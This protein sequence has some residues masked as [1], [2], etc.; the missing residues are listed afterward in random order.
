MDAAWTAGVEYDEEVFDDHRKD[1][2]CESDEEESV[3][4]KE[5][6]QYD[7]MDRN[8][9]VHIMGDQYMVEREN[10]EEE[11]NQSQVDGGSNQEEVD[12]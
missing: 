9:L 11:D 5:E 1:P 10:V 4:D 3:T 12:E 6:E 2:D 7:E 8:E